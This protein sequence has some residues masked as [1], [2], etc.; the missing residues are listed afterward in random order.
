MP[1]IETMYRIWN[2]PDLPIIVCE[3]KDEGLVAIV[4][5]EG[6]TIQL[7]VDTIQSLIICLEKFL[8]T[9]MFKMYNQDGEDITDAP[10]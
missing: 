10:F 2:D 3:G 9:K 6:N 8:P 7:S 1:H 5:G 4:G